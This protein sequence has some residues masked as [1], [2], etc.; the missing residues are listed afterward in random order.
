MKTKQV[1]VTTA[2]TLQYDPE[3]SHFKEALEGYNEVICEADE[4]EFLVSVALFVAEHGTARMMEGV[5]YITDRIPEDPDDL[6]SGI[7]CT[8]REI[9]Y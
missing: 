1:D 7:V 9:Y 2:V 6:W 5:G 8:E 3:S 4:D